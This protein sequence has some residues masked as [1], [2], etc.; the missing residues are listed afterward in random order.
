MMLPNAGF[1]RM[2]SMGR[3]RFNPRARRGPALIAVCGRNANDF[4]KPLVHSCTHARNPWRVEFVPQYVPVDRRDDAARAR[5][6]KRRA[7]DVELLLTEAIH[8]QRLLER[9]GGEPVIENADTASERGLAAGKRCPGHADPRANIRAVMNV[10]LE[11]IPNA[12]GQSQI[13]SE[14]DVVLR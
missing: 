11:L 2:P 8:S 1:G 7:D 13:L 10:C 6:R 3:F 5:V 12:G 14:A 9:T 4:Q